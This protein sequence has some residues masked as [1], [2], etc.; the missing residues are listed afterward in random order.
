MGRWNITADD[1]ITVTPTVGAGADFT[2][3]AGDL[4]FDS[5]EIANA[6]TRPGGVAW[7]QS[8]VVLCK[9]DAKAAFTLVF[10]N[11]S[12]DFGTVDGAPNPD[13]TEALTVIGTVAVAASDYVDLGASSVATLRNIALPLKAAAGATSLYVAGING[14]GTPTFESGGL[15]LKLGFLR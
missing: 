2:F 9:A 5:A 11:A 13:D 15:V 8:I 3:D 6:V 1:V 10:A 14:T 4:I 12:T 7:L